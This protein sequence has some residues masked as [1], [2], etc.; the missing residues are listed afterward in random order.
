MQNDQK[1]V[2]DSAQPEPNMVGQDEAAAARPGKS[3]AGDGVSESDRPQRGR[4]AT[5][6]RTDRGKLHAR[7]HGVLSRNPLEALIRL[8]E[9]PRHL[10]KIKKML[11]A[12]LMPSGLSGKRGQFC[13]T[14]FIRITI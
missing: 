13:Q 3:S 8:G 10:R 1:A 9:T 4:R 5:R 2:N 7:H 11:R 14:S 6:A 12:E